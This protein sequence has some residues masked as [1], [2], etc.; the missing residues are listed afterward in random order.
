MVLTSIPVVMTTKLKSG[1]LLFGSALAP[2]AS[3]RLRG[4]PKRTEQALWEAI[5]IRRVLEPLL[6]VLRRGIWQLL[7]M[8]VRSL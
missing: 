6:Q 1:M 5:R 7:E 2:L 3:T 4:R 8:M